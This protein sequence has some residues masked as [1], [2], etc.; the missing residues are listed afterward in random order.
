MKFILNCLLYAAQWL[1]LRLRGEIFVARD[2]IVLVKPDGRHWCAIEDEVEARLK[3][4]EAA[5]TAN[6]T[7]KPVIC[8]HAQIVCRNDG[9]ECIGTKDSCCEWK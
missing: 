4:R 8:Q 9:E 6:N 2:Y 5:K 1:H 3:A 7:T